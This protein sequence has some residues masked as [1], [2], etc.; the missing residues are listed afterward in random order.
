MSDFFQCPQCGKQYRRENRLVGKAVACECG[1]R[2]LVPPRESQASS[3]ST[4]SLAIPTP[5]MARPAGSA[6]PLRALP[7][8]KLPA[9]RPAQAK[10]ARWSDPVPQDEVVP[11]TDADLIEESAFPTASPLLAAPVA[12]PMANPLAPAGQV[13]PLENAAVRPLPPSRYKPPKPKPARKAN[14]RTS[15]DASS[16]LGV[17]VAGFVLLFSLLPAC[18]VLVLAMINYSA[19]GM[20]N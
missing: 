6:S 5:P 1:R 11:L 20:F 4:S 13:P 14:K 16:T 18:I 7:A 15:R 19:H 9:A 17:W 2:F 8:A 10:P 12:P 3:T